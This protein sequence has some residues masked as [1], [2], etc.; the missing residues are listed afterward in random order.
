LN[1]LNIYKTTLKTFW[2]PVDK[3]KLLCVVSIPS[4]YQLQKQDKPNKT[5]PT[6]AKMSS[7]SL[8]NRDPI[9]P[10]TMPF[11][12]LMSLLW[13]IQREILEKESKNNIGF[14]SSRIKSIFFLS[15]NCQGKWLIFEETVGLILILYRHSVNDLLDITDMDN[16]QHST[17]L[18]GNIASSN[19]IKTNKL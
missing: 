14:K 2:N 8:P 6:S 1:N 18:V 17:S 16:F 9:L 7:V 19:G 13:H 5:N 12:G 4:V 3:V 11:Q 10:Q 15:T